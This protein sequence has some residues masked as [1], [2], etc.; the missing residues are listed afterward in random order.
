M[1][2]VFATEHHP[3]IQIVEGERGADGRGRASSVRGCDASH[4]LYERQDVLVGVWE[5]GR[6]GTVDAFGQ[7]I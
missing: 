4:G 3:E 2:G 6:E 5:K 1:T 7:N